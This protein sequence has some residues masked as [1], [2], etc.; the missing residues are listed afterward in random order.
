MELKELREQP[1]EL[2]PRRE[3]LNFFELTFASVSAYNKAVAVNAFSG[4]SSA[5]ALALQSIN[6]G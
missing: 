4:G 1:V 2:L 5:G 3:A 6:I